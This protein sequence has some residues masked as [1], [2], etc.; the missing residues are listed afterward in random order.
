MKIP[1][2]GNWFCAFQGDGFTALD[3]AQHIKRKCISASLLVDMIYLDTDERRRF[4]STSHEYLIHQ[5]QYNG[6]N[7]ISTTGKKSYNIPMN[8]NH[9]VKELIWMVREKNNPDLCL[10]STDVYMINHSSASALE[11]NY[12][13]IYNIIDT[14]KIML[15]GHDRFKERKHDYFRIVQPYQ[16][17]QQ[18][19]S[20]GSFKNNSHRGLITLRKLDY[21]GVYSFALHPEEHQPSGTLNFSRIDTATMVVNTNDMSALSE[22]Q[23]YELLLWARSYNV[24]RIMSGMGGLAFS[25]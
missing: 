7:I 24:L 16:H 25:S 6:A 2:L 4:A 11:D 9:P 19:V 1:E 14:L 8:F 3:Q 20:F 22:D 17:H 5:T 15:N 12:N 18:S 23:E 10:D 21:Y 13:E